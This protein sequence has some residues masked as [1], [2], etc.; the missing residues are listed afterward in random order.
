MLP[1]YGALH[2]NHL[3]ALQAPAAPQVAV[4][5][6]DALNVAALQASAPQGHQ[7][8]THTILRRSG[9]FFNPEQTTQSDADDL[10]STAALSHG[11]TGHVAFDHRRSNNPT[12][13]MSTL[14]VQ[15]SNAKANS[16]DQASK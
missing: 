1:N 3:S 6:V 15:P 5:K 14:C 10:T 12:Q 16:C 2:L 4:S 7:T 8:M 11:Q 9:L 13:C